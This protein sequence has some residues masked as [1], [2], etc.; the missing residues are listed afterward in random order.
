LAVNA[1]VAEEALP[2]HYYRNAVS[3]V[4]DY[5]FFLFAMGFI[6]AGTV[7]PGLIAQLTPHSE[8][9]VGLL[10]G[11]ISGLWLL[12]Q[13]LIAG[14]VTRLP[15]KKPFIVR[16]ALISRPVMLL[17][18]AMVH[19][20]GRGRPLIA[21]LAILASFS[22]FYIGDALASVPW[23]DVL[24]RAIPGRRRG[25]VLG[26]AQ[27]VG[28]LL[29]ILAGLGVRYA[30]GPTSPWSFP[31][32]YAALFVVSSLAMAG[33]SFALTCLR[34]PPPTVAKG[35]AP[36]LREVIAM[37]PRI[38]LRDR[39]FLRL[40]VIRLVFHFVGMSS[41]FYVLYATRRQGLGLE[42]T[43]LF[44]S[45]QVIGSLASGLLMGVVQDR[46]GPLAHMR[47]TIVLSALP[48]ALALLAGL[49]L[50]ALGGG[51]LPIYLLLYFVLGITTS[52]MGWPFMNWVMEYTSESWRPL[53]LG[54]SNTLGAVSMLAPALAGW[55]AGAFSYTVVFGLSIVLAVI[56][57]LLSLPLL[58][59]RRH[60]PAAR[61]QATP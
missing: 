33:S 60:P 18:A 56:A 51:I 43:G 39:P 13:L 3:F 61:Q 23:F 35:D 42:V 40:N 34:E 10:N 20:F 15:Y 38:L 53:Y 2:P 44:V 36:P 22:L 5:A 57:G 49:L 25:R 37:L 1:P 27:V 45:A 41:A 47:L 55:L 32:N 12:P 16:S 17:C 31:S 46:L 29:G 7:M 58:D 6:S 50:P 26:A 52:V 48:P 9:Y 19:W 21:L 24:S 28:G 59:T 4:A 54:I 14:A 11:L 8:I 30:L